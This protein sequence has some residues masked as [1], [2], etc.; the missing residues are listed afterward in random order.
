[1]IMAVFPPSLLHRYIV[2]VVGGFFSTHRVHRV[3]MV[4]V[5]GFFLPC[6]GSCLNFLSKQLFSLVKASPK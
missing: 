1:M 3:I 5:G 6:H 4:V 2:A